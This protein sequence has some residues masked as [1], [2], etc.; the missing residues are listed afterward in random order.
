MEVFVSAVSM[1]NATFPVVDDSIKEE[2]KLVASLPYFAGSAAACGVGS[3]GAYAGWVHLANAA[4]FTALPV[5]G[6]VAGVALGLF[7]AYAFL[8]T[9]VTCIYSRNAQEFR[10]KI[11]PAIQTAALLV[12]TKM[13][14]VVVESILQALVD[15]M[16]GIQRY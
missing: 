1:D 9:G 14:T 7:G 2:S 3:Y 13:A 6:T 11:G 4:S 16:L 10:E 15:K 5:V 12:V 8:T